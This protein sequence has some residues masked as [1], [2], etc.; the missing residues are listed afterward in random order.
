MQ[1]LPAVTS[2]ACP[3]QVNSR[4]QRP[5]RAPLRSIASPPRLRRP[6][7]R[8]LSV[9]A[10]RARPLRARRPR[11]PRDRRARSPKRA[12][13]Q[14]RYA[15]FRDCRNPERRLRISA[16]GGPRFLPR[17]RVCPDAGQLPA[18]GAQAGPGEEDLRVRSRPGAGAPVRSRKSAPRPSTTTPSSSDSSSASS[19]RPAT[20]KRVS[21]AAEAGAEAARR[22]SRR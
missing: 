3:V 17:S 18:V 2:E 6:R 10:A 11:S 8:K 21:G 1:P 19:V 12:N 9:A 15:G 5:I 20:K 22:P 16:A 7:E 13:A 14:R 4:L